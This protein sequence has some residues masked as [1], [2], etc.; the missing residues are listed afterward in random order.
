MNSNVKLP[1]TGTLGVA[2][3]DLATTQ[4]TI[5]LAHDNCLVKTGLAME[6]P[7]DCSGRIPPRSK[8]ALKKFI[9][10]GASVADSNY[11]GELSVGLFNF[12]KGDLW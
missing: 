9:H 5:V 1:F 8:L 10:V 6:T 11:R 2:S 7:P 12:G 3:S 4:A